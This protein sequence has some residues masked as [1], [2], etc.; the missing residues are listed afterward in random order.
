M[1]AIADQ[2]S[3]VNLMLL[4]IYTRL[5]SQPPSPSRVKLSFSDHSYEYPLG[6]AEDMVINIGGFLYPVDFMIVDRH[7][8]STPII[9]G[10][11]FLATARARIDYDCNTILFKKGKHAQEFPTTPREE[12]NDVPQG[13]EDADGD[14][15]N[16]HVREKILAWEARIKGYKE[17]EMAEHKRIIKNHIKG[18]EEDRDPE[19]FTE[20]DLVLLRHTDVKV[21]PDKSSHWWYGPFTIKGL[22][23]EGMATLSSKRGGE[24]VTN[25]DQLRHHQPD[26]NNHVCQGY[27][28]LLEEEV[29]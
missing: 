6:I 10:E 23:E 13:K 11:P 9:L 18:D 20:G 21:P 12:R 17:A 3:E 4:S 29:T 8:E 2:E 7:N 16:N 5:T 22:Y 1:D 24:V 28:I 14:K 15:R 27:T 19:K 26:Y 25:V